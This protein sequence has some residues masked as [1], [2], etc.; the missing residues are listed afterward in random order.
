MTRL[1]RWAVARRFAKPRGWRTPAA[2]IDATSRRRSS[3]VI[4][5]VSAL[6]GIGN[7]RKKMIAMAANTGDFEAN[8]A[9]VCC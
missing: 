8:L 6:M 4:G 3:G 1:E 7:F 2:R 5:A 9:A